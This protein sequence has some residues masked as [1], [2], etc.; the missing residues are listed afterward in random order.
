MGTAKRGSKVTISKNVETV[1]RYDTGVS[2]ALPDYV[3]KERK[4]EIL[5][6]LKR[7]TTH[8]RTFSADEVP[9]VDAAIA[10]LHEIGTHLVHDAE[11]SEK[12]AGPLFRP[13]FQGVI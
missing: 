9:G 5:E 3:G 6:G 8:V 13:F 12:A 10:L 4:R 11:K 2:F 7:G 1:K